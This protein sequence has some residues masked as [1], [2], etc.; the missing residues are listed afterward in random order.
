MATTAGN[1]IKRKR[2]TDDETPIDREQ[3]TKKL[4]AMVDNAPD[5]LAEVVAETKKTPPQPK[6][7]TRLN[8]HATATK[9]APPRPASPTT[10]A[11]SRGRHATM[12]CVQ[13]PVPRPRSNTRVAMLRGS[14]GSQAAQIVEDLP[15]TRPRTRSQTSAFR[16]VL[17]AVSPAVHRASKAARTTQALT[18]L[19][20]W[21]DNKAH[22][23]N[24]PTYMVLNETV[25]ERIAKDLPVT[26]G[27]L[28]Q[29]GMAV[30]KALAYATEVLE[31]VR[32]IRTHS[33]LRVPESLWDK[34]TKC[35]AG[36]MVLGAKKKK[37][38]TAAPTAF[39]GC[40]SCGYKVALANNT[41][42]GK[43]G[44]LSRLSSFARR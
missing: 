31:V 13:R 38:K 9:L 5:K 10:A 26:V 33:K 25:L 22:E 34:C 20:S 29:S 39:L 17:R 24:I 21:R 19:K 3:F 8:R 30:P 4:A 7:R 12:S 16:R 41:K 27:Q 2:N 28:L 23:Q 1:S 37:S 42:S 6:P 35:D 18:A 36:E 11:R 40:M 44:M 32:D 43:A 14:S 15:E